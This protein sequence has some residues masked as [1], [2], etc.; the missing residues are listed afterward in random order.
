MRAIRQELAALRKL[1]YDFGRTYLAAKF[2]YGKP[3]D[4]WAPR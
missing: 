4:R 2:P 1:F 3:T